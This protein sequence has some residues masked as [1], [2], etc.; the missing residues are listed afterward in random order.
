[1]SVPI[2]ERYLGG[3]AG[4]RGIFGG[5]KNKHR[6]WAL[7]LAAMVAAVLVMTLSGTGLLIGGVVLGVTWV[8]TMPT[9]NV[10]GSV[11]QRR[12]QDRRHRRRVKDGFGEFRPVHTRPE[13]L[14]EPVAGGRAA[15][16]ARFRE[17]NAYRDWP[18]GVTGMQWLEAGVRTPGVAWHTPVG[19]PPYFSVV[20]PVAGQV[21]GMES[22]A[23]MNGYAARFGEL[24]AS[25]GKINTRLRRLQVLTR[26]LPVDSAGHERWAVDNLDLDSEIP[27]ELATSYAD[28]VGRL[29]ETGYMQRHYVVGR[30][31]VDA[32]FMAAAA[33][34]APGAQGWK[35]L[36][37]AEVEMLRRRLTYAGLRPGPAL[38]ARQVAAVI[39]H[40]QMPSWAIDEVADLD[41][42]AHAFLCEDSTAPDY[43]VVRDRGP[44]GVEEEWLHRTARVPLGAL[45]TGMR[46]PLW[47]LPILTGMSVNVIRTVALELETVTAA[48][49]RREAKGDLTSD[50]ANLHKA[51]KE[52]ALEPDELKVAE[53]AVRARVNDL[54]PGSGAHGL[55]WC[56]HLTVSAADRDGLIEAVEL[57]EEAVSNCGISELQ[58]LDGWGQAAHAA[59]WPVA[60]VLQP[61]KQTASM[62]AMDMLS[63]HGRKDG[64]R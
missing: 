7:S 41:E 14:S 35:V 58:W 54:E 18:D 4:S 53:R 12:A 45:E 48:K 63:G 61:H 21:R 22:D 52:G 16:L 24:L 62:R 60:R 57:T 25:M 17:W 20:F 26:V 19:E 32:G 46:D 59:T 9:H 8:V 34:R 42:P 43:T 47:L 55:I 10:A 23:A 3:E 31:P 5:R 2:T 30:W 33:R 39:R 6:T 50:L 29:T 56:M 13:S 37:T 1:M 27:Q 38:S 49:A 64:L 44:E 40:Q 15:K 11:W 51:A 36:M 28:V